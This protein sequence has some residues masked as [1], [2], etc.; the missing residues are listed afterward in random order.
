LYFKSRLYKPQGTPINGLLIPPR[1]IRPIQKFKTSDTAMIF[2]VSA[3][4][5][6][7]SAVNPPRQSVID[8]FPDAV[9][10]RCAF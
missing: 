5:N 6:H 7:I 4:Y 1:R 8:D 10:Y 3:A 2:P 9:V